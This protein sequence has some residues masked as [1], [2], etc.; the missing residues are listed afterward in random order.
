MIRIQLL[1]AG[2]LAVLASPALADEAT[3]QPEVVVTASRTPSTIDDTLADVS[4]ITRADIDAS[5]THDLADLLRLQAGVDIARTGGPGSQTSLFL[6][7]SNNNHVLVLVDGVRVAALGTSVFT[8]ETLPLDTIERIEIVR[9]P[10]ASFWGSDAI[11]GV[12]QIFTRRLDGPR[13]SIGYGTYGDASANVGI[14]HRGDQ[15]GFSVQVGRRDVD[16]FPSQNE[17]GFGFEPK[18]H[19]FDNRH[20][21]ASGDVRVGTQALTAKL[22]RSEGDVEF[23]GGE[24]DFTQ[25]AAVVALE[26]PIGARWTHRLSAGNAREDYETPVYFTAYASR[27]TSFTWQGNLALGERQLL[28]VGVDHLRERG[29]NRDTFANLPVYRESRDD[30]GLYAG[31]RGSFGALDGE[32]AIRHD[33]NSE[34]HGQDTGSAALGWRFSD[35]LRVRASHGQGF[36]GPS[37]NEQ[38]S[39]GFGGLFAGNPDLRPETSRSSELGVDFSPAEGHQLRIS[40]YLTRVRDLISFTGIDFQ[41]ENIARAKIRGSEVRY[42]G[43]AGAWQFGAG[44]TWQDARNESSGTPLLR[45]PGQKLAATVERRFGDALSAGAEV[46]VSGKRA[47]VG[48]IELPG[49]TLFNLRASWQM[50]ADWRAVA[51]LENIGDREYELA[52]GYNT[53]GRAGHLEL[54][55]APR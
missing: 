17:N 31:W 20:L 19:G 23:A 3:V 32:L 28:T 12:V 36:R 8:W 16:G 6:R 29:E 49:Y 52:R 2:V 14:G 35:A 33:D 38:Y 26:G 4:V 45:R 42:D 13:V 34:W 44:F 43:R 1:R 54:V 10:R 9:G 24:S 5:G 39:P 48:G 18:D 30:T 41:A 22:V 55:W 53:P 47:D 46:L 51:R 37:L 21:T 25:Q 11:G 40:A 27:R 50:S 7:G 15:G